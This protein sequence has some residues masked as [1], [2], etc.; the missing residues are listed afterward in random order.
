MME[1]NS[2][3]PDAEEQDQSAADALHDLL[4]QIGE[5]LAYVRHFATAKVDGMRYAMRQMATWV[6]VGLVALLAAAGAL[7]TAIVLFLTG[8][9]QGL[10]MAFGNRMWLGNAVTGFGLLVLMALVLFVGIRRCQRKSYHQRRQAYAE[11]QLQ[12]RAAFGHNVA[13]HATDAAL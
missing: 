11:R 2:N 3:R 4:T 10:A 1:P 8:V 9:A 12:Q 7:V 5:L 13:D 6:A